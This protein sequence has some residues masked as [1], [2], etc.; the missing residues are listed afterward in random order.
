MV[1]GGGQQM[2]ALTAPKKLASCKDSVLPAESSCDKVP[3]TI[4]SAMNIDASINAYCALLGDKNTLLLVK[5]QIGLKNVSLLIDTEASVSCIRPGMTSETMKT[6]PISLTSIHR[7]ATVTTIARFRLNLGKLLLAIGAFEIETEWDVILGN[8]IRPLINYNTHALL[9]D[10][11]RIA[12]K[13]SNSDAKQTPEGNSNTG[14]V[15]HQT[16]TKEGVPSTSMVVNTLHKEDDPAN[17]P[18]SMPSI[19]KQD[20]ST[21]N[22]ESWAP[23]PDCLEPTETPIKGTVPNKVRVRYTQSLSSGSHIVTI[24]PD[25]EVPPDTGWN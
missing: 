16:L 15:S 11:H 10:A 9:I 23:Q 13:Y 7:T 2:R 19:D 14:Q 25:D 22:W 12:F 4:I 21:L 6:T 3:I 20:E 1:V 5:A 24:V 18:L 17:C 8:S